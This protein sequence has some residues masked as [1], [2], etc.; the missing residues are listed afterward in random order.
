MTIIL[1]SLYYYQFSAGSFN[2]ISHR[3]YR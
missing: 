3:I 2:T 1:I